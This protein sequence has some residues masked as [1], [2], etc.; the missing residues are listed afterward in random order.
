MSNFDELIDRVL[1]HE[2][3]Y[4]NHPRDP[5]KETM[6][7]VTE[8]VA[9]ANGYHGNMRE[10]TREQ[11]KAIY[12]AVYWDAVRGDELH[13]A[14]AY[15]LL[16]GAINSGPRQ[17]IKWLQRAIGADD[18]GVMGPKTISVANALHPLAVAAATNAARLSF[19]T[20]LPTWPAFGK[21]WCRRIASNLSLAVQD[22]K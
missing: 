14:I 16:D 11:A 12:R 5:G 1:A 15:Q 8:N 19:L 4:S 2:G 17:A 20:D 3:G 13:K 6:F 22:S 9:R 21:G 10:L 7:G 18:D